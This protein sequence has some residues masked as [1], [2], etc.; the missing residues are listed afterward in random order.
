MKSYPVISRIFEWSTKN[1]QKI[2]IKTEDSEISYGK[3][4]QSSLNLVNFF[5]GNILSS[6]TGLIGLHFEPG[7]ELIQCIIAIWMAGFAYV[8]IDPSLPRSRILKMLEQ[9]DLQAI[10]TADQDGLADFPHALHSRIHQFEKLKNTQSTKRKRVNFTSDDLAYIIFTSGSTGLPKGVEITQK[11]VFNLLNSFEKLLECNQ[12]DKLLSITSFSFDIF[13]LEFLLPLFCGGMVYIAPKY[14]SLDPELL[15]HILQSESIS[16]FQGTPTTFLLLVEENWP[17]L[18]LRHILC[19][20]ENWG[21][22]LAFSILKKKPKKCK[23]WNVYGPTETTVWSSAFWVKEP[24]KIYLTPALQ[25]TRFLLYNEGSQDKKSGELFISGLGVGRGYHNDSLLTKKYF[26]KGISSKKNS[27]YKTGDYVER[28]SKDCYRF[29]GRKDMQ[30][31]IRG[32]RVELGEIEATLKRHPQI[33]EAVV[34]Y[35]TDGNNITLIAFVIYAENATL[36]LYAYCLEY[37]PIYM[38]PQKFIRLDKF[39]LTHNLKVDRKALMQNI[40]VQEN[41]VD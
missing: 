26:V 31:K 15:L 4:V 40:T 11:S 36:D 14:A 13:L 37:L 34:Q 23:L 6:G 29:I 25:N 33:R 17:D 7:I 10:V 9:I 20:G 24:T 39:P 19:G 3:L 38:L 35:D 41:V 30:L 5:S 16:I 8:P 22:K 1:P 12:R 32:Y 18:N 2:A 28:I 21:E 27:V